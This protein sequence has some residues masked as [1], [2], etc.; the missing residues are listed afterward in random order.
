MRYQR[1]ACAGSR[2]SGLGHPRRTT[3]TAES[4]RVK[5]V[6]PGPNASTNRLLRLV[7]M[8]RREAR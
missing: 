7:R 1:R 2:P 6:K 4:Y 3:H 5:Y 8:E